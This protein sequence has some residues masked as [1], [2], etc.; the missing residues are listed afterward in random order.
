MPTQTPTQRN[1]AA[2]K[3]AATRKRN[4]AA[5]RRSAQKAAE[6]RAQAELTGLGAV[7]AQAERAVLIPVGAALVAG[8]TVVDAVTDVTKPYTSRETASRE[9]TKLQRQVTRDLKRF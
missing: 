2:R 6:T 3:A 8:E 1:A 7:Q 9:L 4:A 5:R